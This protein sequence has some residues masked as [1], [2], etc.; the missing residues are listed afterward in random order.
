MMNEVDMIITA[1]DVTEHEA[2]CFSAEA[3]E[4]RMRP[5][6]WPNSIRTTMG[7]KQPFL[8]IS[9]KMTPGG[10][11]GAMLYQQSMGCITLTIWND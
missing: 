4:L 11:L 6:E 5:G 1:S 3:S 7:N 2:H 10:D 8:R 9:A